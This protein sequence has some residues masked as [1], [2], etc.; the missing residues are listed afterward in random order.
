MQK[1]TLADFPGKDWEF[2]QDRFDKPNGARV[3][4]LLINKNRTVGDLQQDFHALFPFLIIHFY[5]ARYS[6]GKLSASSKMYRVDA[7]LSIIQKKDT[8]GSFQFTP[9]TTVAEFEQRMWDE[10]GLCVQVLRS[11]GSSWIQTSLTD[12]WTL[13]RQNEEGEELSH[14]LKEDNPDLTDRDAWE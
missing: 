5:N 1:I 6:T 4:E 2:Q 13:E 3:M 11:S 7:S 12:S 8:E 14:P 9:Q 10:Y